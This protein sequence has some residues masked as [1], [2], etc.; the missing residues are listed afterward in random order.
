[1]MDEYLS[2]TA[3]FWADFV[4]WNPTQLT[5]YTILGFG[6]LSSW[7]MT[8]FAAKPPLFVGPISFMTLSF[9]AMISNFAG[10]SVVM[11]GTSEVQKALLF[12][13]IGHSVA[14]IILLAVLRVGASAKRA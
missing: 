2:I 6:A 8:R 3:R 9:A 14:G 4:E 7:I 10:R 11:M 1:M 12:T 5:L 13:V